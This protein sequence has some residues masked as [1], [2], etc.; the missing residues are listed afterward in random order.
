MKHSIFKLLNSII[1]L[2]TVAC[3]HGQENYGLTFN[4]FNVR[5][6]KRTSLVIGDSQ[7]LCLSDNMDISFDFY[8]IPDR[9]IYFGYLFRMINNDGQNIDL[10]YNQKEEIF[11]TIIGDSFCNINFTIDKSELYHKWT[12]IRYHI[13]KGIL[14]CYIN[15]KLYKTAPVSLKDNC[16]KVVF[17]SCDYKDFSTTNVPPMVIRNIGIADQ[18]KLKYFWPLSS[19]EENDIIEDSI[20]HLIAKA[21]NP[22]WSENLHK[23]WQLLTSIEVNGK[24]SNT[25]DQESEQFY[26]VSED[27]V[28]RLPITDNM[29]SVQTSPS[30]DYH[31]FWGNLT[32]YNTTNHQLYNFYVDIKSVAEYSNTSYNW[33][34]SYDT[35]EPTEYNHINKVFLDNQNAVYIFGGYGQLKYK[36]K[37]QRYDFNEKKWELLTPGGTYF[38]PRYMAASAAFGDSIYIL[39]GY[40]SHSGDQEL[41]PQHLYDLLL[42][43]TKTNN[44]KN[45]YTLKEPD[46]QFSFAGSMYI[47]SFRQCYYA[48]CF[49]D[50][51]F[52]SRLQ[53]IKG[54]LHSPEYEFLGDTIPYIFRDVVSNADLFYSRKNSQLLAVTSFFDENKYKT[55]IKIYSISFPPIASIGKDIA[56][57][58]EPFSGK[59]IFTGLLILSALII[60]GTIVYY[61][62]RRSRRTAFILSESG[63]TGIHNT[64]KEEPG[65]EDTISEHSI[66]AN[67]EVSKYDK[68]ATFEPPSFVMERMPTIRIYMFGTFEIVDLRNNEMSNQFSPLLKELF[69]I[70]LLHVLK[71]GKGITTSKLNDIFWSNKTDKNAKNNLSVNIVRLK[72]ILSKIGDIYIKKIEERWVCEF[73]PADVSIDLLDYEKLT[74]IQSEHGR[75]RMSNMLYFISRGA[76]LKQTESSWLDNIK[77]EI[78]NQIIDGLLAECKYLNAQNDLEYVVEAADSIFNFDPLNEEALFLKCKSL[79]HMGRP[80]QAQKTYERFTKSYAKTYGEEFSVSYNEFIKD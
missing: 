49:D 47:D 24:A 44:F 41:K 61:L 65:E 32:I 19:P 46:T 18:E 50:S 79:N 72:N 57:T 25:F 26:I 48:L 71:H 66:Y 76:F 68:K 56:A 7:P 38:T 59:S 22:V 17:G 21:S 14:Y 28:Y 5:Q 51:K 78:N 67:H 30:R 36:N 70:I 40:G 23:N 52:D 10:V 60:T 1:L 55:T 35:I 13:S 31:L 64:Q 27:S 4:S 63:Y 80:L 29:S 15:Q 43:N 8:L 53:L 9:S 2:H 54:A 75:M 3:L 39:G 77:A 34:K 42:Y 62:I 37:V 73:D 16:F 69:L 45:I 6:E 11:N 12:N 33:S 58:R 74:S 20:H